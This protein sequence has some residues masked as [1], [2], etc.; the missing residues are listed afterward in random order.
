M[1]MK[2]L[3]CRIVAN[4]FLARVVQLPRRAL[5]LQTALLRVASMPRTC[6]CV[7][8]WQPARGKPF[9]I[10]ECDLLFVFDIVST[11][12]YI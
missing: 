1:L 8:S 2:G 11:V 6:A 10:Y 5:V 12:Q 4:C 3:F 7:L 9:A